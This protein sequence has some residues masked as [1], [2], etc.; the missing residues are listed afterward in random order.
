[1]IAK[2][3]GLNI[4][5]VFSSIQGEGAYVG[6]RQVFVRLAGCN[7]D[8][9]YCDTAASQRISPIAE[10]ENTAGQQNFIKEPNPL[11]G[12]QLAI[13]INQLLTTPHHSVSLTGGE[14]LCQAAALAKV[15]PL[16]KGR[17]FL[18]TNGTL[19][20]ELA[21]LLPMIDIIS[22][23][24]KL[25]SSMSGREYWPQHEAFLA[26]ANTKEVYVKM[27][28]SASTTNQEFLKALQL[29]SSVNPNNLLVLQPITTTQED[30]KISPARIYELQE[31]ALNL[32]PNVRVI[33]QTH[34]YIGV[35]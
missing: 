35:L 16:I 4:I 13:H 30:L 3:A 14:P 21:I 5:E 27:V 34:K 15:L 33:P 22:M 12:Q 11:S 17:F 20:K 24:I 10:L 28:V 8:C 2:D 7:L 1:M 25:P 19:V 29:I 26:L 6:C 32:L 18:E 23:D 9:F 31:R